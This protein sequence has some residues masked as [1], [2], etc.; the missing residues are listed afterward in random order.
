MELTFQYLTP[1]TKTGSATTYAIKEG[2]VNGTINNTGSGVV[3]IRPEGQ[4][5][6]FTIGIGEAHNFIWCNGKGLYNSR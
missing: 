3:L 6:W 5:D 2:F 4:T 1:L